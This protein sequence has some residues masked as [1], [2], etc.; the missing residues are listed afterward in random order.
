MKELMRR[1][2]SFGERIFQNTY[3]S[4]NYFSKIAI[5]PSFSFFHFLRYQV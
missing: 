4:M 5:F 2:L 3:S 1:S